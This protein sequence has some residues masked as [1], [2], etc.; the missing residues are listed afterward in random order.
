MDKDLI[1]ICRRH[2]GKALTTSDIEII[3]KDIDQII[4]WSKE[5]K[6]PVNVDKRRVIHFG[7]RSCNNS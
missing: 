5:W 3:Q 6:M 7:L 4:Q 1:K 2:Q